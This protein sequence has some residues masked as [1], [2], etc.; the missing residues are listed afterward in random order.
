MRRSILS[1]SSTRY[2]SDSAHTTNL[3][4]LHARH[5][6]FSPASIPF[7]N[8]LP[9]H[10]NKSSHLGR[11]ASQAKTRLLE[12]TWC[13]EILSILHIQEHVTRRNHFSTM[14][15][16]TRPVPWPTTTSRP[17]SLNHPSPSFPPVCSGNP[18]SILNV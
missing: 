1:R 10:G 15:N 3:A 13:I 4:S 16:L 5:P 7:W 17:F 14:E 6:L 2:L 11:H 12:K 18:S 8:C 9:T